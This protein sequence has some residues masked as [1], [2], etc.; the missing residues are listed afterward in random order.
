M[1]GRRGSPAAASASAVGHRG[2]VEG[3]ADEPGLDPLH[4]PGAGDRHVRV[5]VLAAP[6]RSVAGT[7]LK[8]TRHTG[9]E[10]VDRMQQPALEPPLERA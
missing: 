4:A 7:N 10:E 1:H 9:A 3:S 6:H 5:E 2:R 8:A